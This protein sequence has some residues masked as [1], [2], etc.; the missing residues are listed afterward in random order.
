MAK[1]TKTQFD[2]LQKE[3][4]ALKA[5][6]PSFLDDDQDLDLSKTGPKPGKKGKKTANKGKKAKVT[7]K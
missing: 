2:Q 4:S 3:L 6:V 5:G 1:L 7:A